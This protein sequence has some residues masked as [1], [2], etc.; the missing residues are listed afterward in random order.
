[1]TPG[2]AARRA[3]S[4]SPRRSLRMN[5][6]TDKQRKALGRGL[7]TLLPAK[8]APAAPS[9]PPEPAAEPT[10]RLPIDKIEPNPMQPR[11]VFHPE[12]LQELANSIRANGVI[13]PMIVRRAGA[14]FQI[15]AGERRWRAAQLA[16]LTEVPVVIQEVADPQLLQIA[17]IENIQRE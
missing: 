16:G 4:S 2:R 8:A 12:R 5:S 6:G 13:Q 14:R 9:A 17:L 7:S 11:T 10:N 15:V 3:T 1:M